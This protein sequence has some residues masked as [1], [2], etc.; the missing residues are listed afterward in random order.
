MLAKVIA[1]ATE[2]ARCE[3]F[4]LSLDRGRRLLFWVDARRHRRFVEQVAK[5][6]DCTPAELIAGRDR[7]IELLTA[8]ETVIHRLK[9]QQSTAPG[10]PL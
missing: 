9:G 7:M 5:H 1:D 10:A 2:D 4:L 8:I 3:D 6:G